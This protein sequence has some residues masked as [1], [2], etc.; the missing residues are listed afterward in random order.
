MAAMPS[1]RHGT[2]H[3]WIDRPTLAELRREI[4]GNEA[5]AK[6]NR[7]SP[8]SRDQGRSILHFSALSVLTALCAVVLWSGCG[9]TSSVQGSGRA[10]C[11]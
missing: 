2:Q 7:L 5:A 3:R 9:D 6:Y 1:S 8:Q 10:Q 4:R 11:L